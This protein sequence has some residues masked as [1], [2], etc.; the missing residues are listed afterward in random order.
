MLLARSFCFVQGIAAAPMKAKTTMK[1]IMISSTSL[2]GHE[3]TEGFQFRWQVFVS[4]IP[5]GVSCL[6]FGLTRIIDDALGSHRDGQWLSKRM[7][8][9]RKW[10]DDLGLASAQ[11][12]HDSFGSF[13]HAERTGRDV[14]IQS[15][16]LDFSL[17]PQAL[18][19]I[20]A[21]LY[22]SKMSSTVDTD[23]MVQRMLWVLIERFV[24][25]DGS[26]VPKTVK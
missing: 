24:P 23:Q 25:Q 12:I 7:S 8:T 4:R 15:Y 9:F 18:F 13:S 16:D 6:R 10:V 20:I 5:K 2:K 3:D 19:V 1:A 14:N 26:T 17:S 11:H 21:G 22:F